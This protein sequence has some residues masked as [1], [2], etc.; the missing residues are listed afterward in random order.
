MART[1]KRGTKKSSAKAIMRS[2][3]KLNPRQRKQVKR[4]VISMAEK[5]FHDSNSTV[6]PSYDNATFDHISDIPQ[7]STD[8]GRDG[9]TVRATSVHIK[10]LVK[11][12]R[13]ATTNT[14]VLLILF[15]EGNKAMDA[16]S[17]QT[18]VMGE[19]MQLGATAVSVIDEFRH[20]T[21]PRFQVLYDRLF[22]NN[23]NTGTALGRVEKFSRMI[24][25]KNKVM[26][27]DAGTSRQTKNALYLVAFSD[28]T[29]ASAAESDLVYKVRLR[30]ND[31]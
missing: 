14:R 6:A 12:S 21:R 20:D 28:V 9:D 1:I 23:D 13:D 29:D 26:Q 8:T 11:F 2:R 17:T 31:I 24:P 22:T 3:A 19:I 25:L 15:K 4:V 10:G 5:K 7:N 18:P 16:D 27:Y 30:F